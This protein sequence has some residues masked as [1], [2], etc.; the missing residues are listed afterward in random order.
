[1]S[2]Y[3][4]AIVRAPL[5]GIVFLLEMTGSFENLFPL[6]LISVIAS[7]TADMLRSTPI[8]DALLENMLK[9]HKGDVI[10]D[11][12]KKITVEAVVHYGA[13]A[14]GRSVREPHDCLLITVRREGK[15]IIPKGNTVLRAN[16]ALIFLISVHYE[17]QLRECISSLT[18]NA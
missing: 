12:G 10:A 17:A 5:T 14:A 7:A 11:E 15:E 3:F 18:E 13:Y 2:G 16:D 1:M 4:A 8:Y 6:V 9:D